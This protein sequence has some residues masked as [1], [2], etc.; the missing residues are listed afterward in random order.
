MFMIHDPLY[1]VGVR[2]EFMERTCGIFGDTL[3]HLFL[4]DMDRAFRVAR[5]WNFDLFHNILGDDPEFGAYNRKI[6][7]VWLDRWLPKTCEAVRAFQGIYD[8]R[9]TKTVL[10]QAPLEK[11]TPRLQRL[12]SKWHETY[13]Q[14]LGLRVDV[15]AI[16]QLMGV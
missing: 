8:L 13:I 10:E 9:E 15:D 3:T 11:I 14:P 2:N 4:P 5:D 1:G 7:Q 12:I 6:M 16:K